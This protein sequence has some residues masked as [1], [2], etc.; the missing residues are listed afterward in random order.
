MIVTGWPNDGE[1][2]SLFEYVVVLKQAHVQLPS[3]VECNVHVV[4][5][6]VDGLEGCE[7][8]KEGIGS[9]GEGR[10]FSKQAAAVE[11]IGN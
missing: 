3:V 2:G 6:M 5:P 11:W 10:G 4:G 1:A 9:F 7:A 8:I